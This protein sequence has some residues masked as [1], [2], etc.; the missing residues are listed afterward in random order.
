[1]IHDRSKARGTRKGLRRPRRFSRPVRRRAA[2]PDR[3]LGFRY[4]NCKSV[5][6][7]LT[8]SRRRRRRSRDDHFRRILT[9]PI[10]RRGGSCV[11]EPATPA[12]KAPKM[13][14]RPSSRRASAWFSME[15]VTTERVA[16]STE[17]AAA[18]VARPA[19]GCRRTNSSL[20]GLGCLE[21]DIAS[22]ADLRRER[23]IST[24]R[25]NSTRPLAFASR[26]RFVRPPPLAT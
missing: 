24:H 22:V 7:R 1:M 17:A 9:M 10:P 5:G 14:F 11:A 15:R 6:F 3:L 4:L 18:S 23:R 19:A 25:R 21:C 20:G 26:R 2:D 16:P 13:R 12:R 8:P